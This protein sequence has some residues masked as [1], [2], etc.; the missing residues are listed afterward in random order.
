MNFC[1]VLAQQLSGIGENDLEE[2]VIDDVALDRI[3]SKKIRETK[4]D[5]NVNTNCIINHKPIPVPK[6]LRNKKYDQLEKRNFIDL[7]ELYDKYS[8]MK[9]VKE[10]RFEA[11]YIA[12][13]FPS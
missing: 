10:N 5:K 11:P 13:L 4:P 3:F 1:V 6:S 9:D 12:I 2:G 8:Y 7:Y